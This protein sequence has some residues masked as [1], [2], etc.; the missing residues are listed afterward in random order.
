MGGGWVLI[1]GGSGGIGDAVCRRLAVLGRRPLVGYASNRAK[2]E[3]VAAET[4]GLAVALDLADAAQI[5]AAIARCAQLPEPLEG[6]VLAAS[7]PPALGPLH[8]VDEREMDLQWRINVLGPRRLL[9]GLVATCWRKAKAGGVVAVLTQAMGAGD[10][11][12]VAGMGPY[13]IA[14]HGLAGLLAAAAADYKWLRVAS[15]S[16]GYT[17]TGM[18]GA[19]DPRFL[20]LVRE[21]QPGGRFTAPEDVAADIVEL[22]LV[23]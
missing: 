5:D 8:R 15:V 11:S 13:V 17:E 2:G 18:L 20:E 23:P 21:S 9:A 10:G 3:M 22:L 4:G 7:P 16:P 12:A 6:L 14:K 19:F 1:S